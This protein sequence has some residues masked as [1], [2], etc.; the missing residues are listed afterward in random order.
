MA[1]NTRPYSSPNYKKEEKKK[2]DTR[3]YSSPNYPKQE[4]SKPQ[5]KPTTETRGTPYTP[6]YNTPKP[7]PYTPPYQTQTQQQN[8][9]AAVSQ[10]QQP[11]QH[12]VQQQQTVQQQQQ[13]NSTFINSLNNTSNVYGVDAEKINNN[14]EIAKQLP[15]TR[16]ASI[17]KTNASIRAQN[18]QLQADLKAQRQNNDVIKAKDLDTYANSTYWSNGRKQDV[19][20]ATSIDYYNME[21]SGYEVVYVENGTGT[22]TNKGG[23]YTI[24][25]DN[26]A[27]LPNNVKTV[28]VDND[29]NWKYLVDTT[30]RA[31]HVD[32]LQRKLAAVNRIYSNDSGD[33]L[34]QKE[35]ILNN[36][37]NKRAH[38]LLYKAKVLD[39]RYSET[40]NPE[41]L[42]QLSATLSA[43]NAY[44]NVIDDSTSRLTAYGK[45]WAAKYEFYDHAINKHSK[46]SVEDE[47]QYQELLK[48]TV[49]GDLT[50]EMVSQFTAMQKRREANKD[51]AAFLGKDYIL[52]YK[53]QEDNIKKAVDEYN[54][55]DPDAVHLEKAEDLGTQF[56][57]FMANALI[58]RHSSNLFEEESKTRREAA[59]KGMGEAIKKNFSPVA[60]SYKEYKKARDAYKS[61]TK[62]IEEIQ[63]GETIFEYSA[64]EIANLEAKQTEYLRASENAIIQGKNLM[65]N[66]FI[67]NLSVFDTFSVQS[68]F[69]AWRMA[70]HPERYSNDPKW[71]KMQDA[72][73]AIM[74]T[75]WRNDIDAGKMAQAMLTMKLGL[76]NDNDYIYL[77]GSDLRHSYKD[78]NGEYKKYGF[79]G[80]LA[81][82]MLTD[83]SFLTS[84]AKGISGV[85]TNKIGTRAVLDTA[86][87]SFTESLIR[88]GVADSTAKEFTNTSIV[89]K[90]LRK[91]ISTAIKKTIKEGGDDLAKTLKETILN[92]AELLNDFAVDDFKRLIT[93]N[94]YD[95]FLRNAEELIT[96]SN[97]IV[98]TSL[99]IQKGTM[100]THALGT[101]DDTLNEM[102]SV[103]FK[104]TCPVAGA[105]V[106]VAHIG[107]A[108][109]NAHNLKLAQELPLYSALQTTRQV[110][111]K[112][113][114][115][116]FNSILDSSGFHKQ[117]QEIMDE[118]AYG[119]MGSIKQMPGQ[120]YAKIVEPLKD[121]SDYLL[122]ETANSYVHHVISKLD[123][124]LDTLNITAF[125]NTIQIKDVEESLAKLAQENGYNTFDEMYAVIKNNIQ[126]IYDASPDARH[127]VEAFD[128]KYSDTML[129]RSIDNIRNY[130]SNA[131][132][133]LAYIKSVFNTN[134][135][136]VISVTNARL[137]PEFVI[138]TADTTLECIRDFLRTVNND[139]TT[140]VQQADGLADEAL[141]RVH[142]LHETGMHTIDA[143]EDIALGDVSKDTINKAQAWLYKYSY[144]MDNIYINR[145]KQWG[146]NIIQDTLG[147]QDYLKNINAS[148]PEHAGNTEVLNSLT[149]SMQKF[150]AEKGIN[151]TKEELISNVIKENP[152][153]FLKLS[154]Q[155]QSLLIYRVMENKGSMITGQINNAELKNLTDQLVDCNA[156]LNKN[157]R[158]LQMY[159]PSNGGSYSA[160]NNAIS[161]ACAMSN[162]RMISNYLKASGVD[163]NMHMAMD[164][165]HC[166][167]NS[168]RTTTDILAK[169]QRSSTCRYT[170][171]PYFPVN[172]HSRQGRV[173]THL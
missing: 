51:C 103:L 144:E 69:V 68:T 42:K 121:C 131:E 116:G 96:Q 67:A 61:A 28:L 29:G 147:V 39:K 126:V 55:W 60:T 56:K 169:K 27:G 24:G 81:V 12:V 170:S 106:G 6:T 37:A 23:V 72:F 58:D 112:I 50:P 44:Q 86:S 79:L 25:R 90:A 143:L 120:D 22:L 128:R 119:V 148:V 57:R 59:I 9:P 161:N 87:E 36:K 150:F 125:G 98:N 33:G 38:K 5:T 129:K 74:G 54:K 80:S 99:Q 157:L 65:F 49:H 43:L 108:I 19:S 132:E 26:L 13:T 11:Q 124:A 167:Y 166:K 88:A 89:Q 171:V 156:Q 115:L 52:K 149:E 93:K 31:E 155:Q 113:E 8:K 40:K 62:R 154:T 77:D 146:Q 136:S 45:E 85:A 164:M 16:L 48:N 83:V 10:P 78:S 100:L 138:G 14:V 34:F 117:W 123:D 173:D 4:T 7:T 127:I 47:S 30:S 142:S 1:N 168:Y 53:E 109:K 139:Y 15:K 75:G 94:Q 160:I 122:R 18:K 3:P 41:V 73:E 137:H 135:K 104:S 92:R 134:G 158:L 46:W 32:A 91:D 35:L 111:A 20:Y 101:I 70:A 159:F 145:L 107:K 95:D 141:A 82:G 133:H 64:E 102:Q 114:N 2:Q 105:V 63:A 66:N 152:D 172:S 84:I 17:N 118:W 162:T 163:N 110:Y 130:V 97:D 151:V 21:R 165:L 71:L 140:I 153:D 76:N